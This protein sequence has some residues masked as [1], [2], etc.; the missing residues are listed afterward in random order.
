MEDQMSTCSCGRKSIKGSEY[1]GSISGG[2]P[3][4]Y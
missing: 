3:S 1:G 4:V 2:A